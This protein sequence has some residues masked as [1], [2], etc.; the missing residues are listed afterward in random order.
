MTSKRHT[1]R[2]ISSPLGLSEM[3][4]VV[5]TS[6]VPDKIPGNS[7]SSMRPPRQVHRPSSYL[8]HFSFSS[9]CIVSILLL[10]FHICL[11]YFS[12]FFF[13]PCFLFSY[14]SLIFLLIFICFFFF[15]FF[16]LFLNKPLLMCHVLRKS[17]ILDIIS[18][19][20]S[21]TTNKVKKIVLVFLFG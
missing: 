19:T 2:L 10:L 8:S 21:R 11:R 16:L 20:R 18:E 13:S 1:I 14:P 9:M 3:E 6:S 15:L 7:Q 5:N 12:S 17:L 4:S